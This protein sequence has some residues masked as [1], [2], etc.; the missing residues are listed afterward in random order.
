MFL[1]AVSIISRNWKQHRFLSEDEWVK[2][3]WH[4]YTIQFYS[5][6]KEKIKS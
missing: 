3:M 4:I 5:T 6:A 1:A 2:K